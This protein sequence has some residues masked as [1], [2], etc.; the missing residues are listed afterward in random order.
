MGRVKLEVED[1]NP[2]IV[3]PPLQVRTS[4]EKLYLTQK[5]PLECL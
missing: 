1:T 4:S 5:N 2:N 3:I